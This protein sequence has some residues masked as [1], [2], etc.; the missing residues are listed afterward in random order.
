MKL[1]SNP[2]IE[3]TI[4]NG[5]VAVIANAIDAAAL[6]GSGSSNQPTGILQTTGV[7]LTGMEQ[8]QAFTKCYTMKI[9]Q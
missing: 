3:S 4:R 9:L 1:Q 7:T 5:F 8:I 6:N 2:E